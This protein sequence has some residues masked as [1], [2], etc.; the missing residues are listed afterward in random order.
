MWNSGWVGLY[1]QSHVMEVSL[2]ISISKNIDPVPLLDLLMP[3]KVLGEF[4][5]VL[6]RYDVCMLNKKLISLITFHLIK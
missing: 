1:T 5:D 6:G 3:I 4:I 2:T